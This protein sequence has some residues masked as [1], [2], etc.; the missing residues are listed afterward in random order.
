MA[1]V[2]SNTVNGVKKCDPKT[3]LK[4]IHCELDAGAWWKFNG[5]VICDHVTKM[6]V[7]QINRP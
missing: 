2:A 3:M 7:T 6:A 4:S 5:I 1:I